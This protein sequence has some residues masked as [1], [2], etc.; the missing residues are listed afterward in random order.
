MELTFVILQ[1]CKECSS[2]CSCSLVNSVVYQKMMTI[3]GNAQ[4]HPQLCSQCLFGQA[5][6]R[7][8]PSSV[9]L[10]AVAHPRAPDSARMRTTHA[11]PR[12]QS[13]VR[14]AGSGLWT[15]DSCHQTRSE[16]TRWEVRPGDCSLCPPTRDT[17]GSPESQGRQS[18]VC[19]AQHRDTCHVWM[20]AVRVTIVGRPSA[21]P[22]PTWWGWRPAAA[23]GPGCRG[24]RVSGSASPGLCP[25]VAPC[26]LYQSGTVTRPGRGAATVTTDGPRCT[27]SRGWGTRRQSAPPR[28]RRCPWCRG[29]RWTSPGCSPPGPVSAGAAAAARAPEAARPSV[30][31]CHTGAVH[32]PQSTQTG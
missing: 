26:P 22:A 24:C 20:T 23:C 8:I 9:T 3:A 17:R 10:C 28:C 13:R 19:R 5:H 18:H 31:I 11:R 12:A 4:W 7:V 30:R 14:G 6:T 15:G 16:Y 21:P 27:G 1:D 2:G 29:W 32:H 25:R